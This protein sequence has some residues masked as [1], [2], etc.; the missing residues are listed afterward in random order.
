[1]VVLE[2][3]S[4]GMPVELRGCFGPLALIAA[5][6]I[7]ATHL[8]DFAKF[9][10]LS[11]YL[12]YFGACL[13]AIAATIRLTLLPA[14]NWW[15][16]T[17]LRDAIAALACLAGLA[18]IWLV[19]P[20]SAVTILWAGVALALVEIGVALEE[21]SFRYLGLATLAPVYIRVF[22]FDLDHFAMADVPFAIGAIY[23]IWQRFSRTPFWSRII[24]WAAIFPV[25]FLIGDEAGAHNAPL[26][27]VLA[28]AVLLAAGNRFRIEDAR[29]Q[30]YAMAVLA[31]GAAIWFEVDP[32]RLWISTL[33]VAGPMLRNCWR[34]LLKRSPRRRFSRCWGHCCSARSYMGALRAN[35]SRCRGDCRGFACW[36]SGLCSGLAYSDCRAS[37]CC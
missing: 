19:T 1:M 14:E 31:F 9:P 23:W 29:L 18:G 33:T 15:E 10:A 17:M 27:W 21:P 20:A 35:C 25:V 34:N 28:A 5:G 2:L 8:D 13:C 30:S 24:F 37:R 6:A 12:T 26:G 22:A 36:E 4:Y 16:R 7:V 3:G 11:V 32:P